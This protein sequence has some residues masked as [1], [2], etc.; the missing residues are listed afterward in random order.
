MSLILN[1]AVK[2]GHTIDAASPAETEGQLIAEITNMV[3]EL[4]P[5]SWPPPRQLRP[6]PTLEARPPGTRQTQDQDT[7][8]AVKLQ[9]PRKDA[10]CVLIEWQAAEGTTPNELLL[11]QQ[12]LPSL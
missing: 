4:H 7:T 10:G 9:L 2:T 3:M 11:N 8:G 5:C 1:N 12:S 6:M